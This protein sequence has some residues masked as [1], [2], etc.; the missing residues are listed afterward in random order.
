MKRL[1][2][3]LALLLLSGCSVGAIHHKRT[4]APEP[5]D[6]P[7]VFD[8]LRENRLA[9]VSAHRGQPHPEAAENALSSFAE[10]LGEGPILIEMD[11]GR[12]ADGALVLLHDDRLE[13]TTTGKGQLSAIDYRQLRWLHLETPAG[14]R[15]DERVPSLDEALT[16][17]K[18]NGAIL[19][20][21]LKRGVPQAEVLAAVRRARMERQVI[22]ITYTP[23]AARAALA[24]DPDIMVSASASDAR[25]WQAVLALAGPRLVAFTGTAEPSDALL[26][27][28][29]ARGIEAVTGTLG[30][31][32]ARLDDRYM[33][34]GDGREYAGLAARGVSL[35][36]SDRPVDAWEALRDARRDGRMCLEGKK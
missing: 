9:L 10:T 5:P 14:E 18:R 4:A 13:R 22:L 32:G 33:A 34:D 31:A 19:Q 8:C 3:F 21:D 35:I 6:L 12:T 27:S 7:A 36:A 17:A 2:P 11:I 26:A 16:W 25:G 1:A 15:L 28:L 24:A 30:R 20:L 29:A 23:A